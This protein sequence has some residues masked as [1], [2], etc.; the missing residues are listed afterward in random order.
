MYTEYE[1]FY[2][3]VGWPDEHGRFP[4]HV[5]QSPR[6][7][8][9]Q[10]VWQENKL[11]LPASQHILDYLQELIAEPDEVELLGRSLHEFLFPAEVDDIFPPLPRR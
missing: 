8:T 7:E 5:V 4:I 11:Q 9:R 10:P 3:H 6:G 1:D 2:L